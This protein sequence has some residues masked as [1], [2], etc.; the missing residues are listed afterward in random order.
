[1]GQKIFLYILKLSLFANYYG[2]VDRLSLFIICPCF[3]LNF[4]FAVKKQW[5]VVPVEIPIKK[6]SSS[7]GGGGRER[8]SGGGALREREHKEKYNNR[9]EERNRYLSYCLRFSFLLFMRPGG[10]K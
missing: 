9:E 5:T 2:S 3:K 4:Y 6:K 10:R 1:M 8:R 7:S